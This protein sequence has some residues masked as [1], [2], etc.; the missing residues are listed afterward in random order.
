VRKVN[1]DPSRR[2]T[3]SKTFGKF[4]WPCPINGLR[5]PQDMTKNEPQNRRLA[6]G[7]RDPGF[8]NSNYRD[9]APRAFL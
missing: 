5:F 3:K 2:F 1:G 8:L 6:Q 7:S 4:S 9:T